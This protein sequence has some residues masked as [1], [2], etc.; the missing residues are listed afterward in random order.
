M[1]DLACEPGTAAACAHSWKV[2][3]SEEVSNPASGPSAF[4]WQTVALLRCA[5]CGD[6][7][8]RVLAGRWNE[9]LKAAGSGPGA[10]ETTEEN[11][12]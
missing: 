4:G 11:D 10:R 12:D 1:A 5:G 3:T 2:L 6:I 7:A 8:S 9:A